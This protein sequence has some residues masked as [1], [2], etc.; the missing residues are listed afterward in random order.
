MMKSNS[1]YKM[2]KTGK[3]A[4][5]LHLNQDHRDHLRRMIIDSELSSKVIRTRRPRKE[6]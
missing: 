6:G 2:S 3:R 1:S 5:A 4:L